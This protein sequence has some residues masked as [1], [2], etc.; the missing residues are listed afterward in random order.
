VI[1]DVTIEVTC[2]RA[3]CEDVIA[4]TPEY[5]FSGRNEESGH[6]DTSKRALRKLVEAQDWFLADDNCTTYCETHK[7]QEEGET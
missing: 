6:Y 4:I 5:V 1:G 2:D 7:P 3:N